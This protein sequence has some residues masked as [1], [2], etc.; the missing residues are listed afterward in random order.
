MARAADVA[1]D[2]ERR[3]PGRAVAFEQRR[4]EIGGALDLRL[5]LPAEAGEISAASAASAASSTVRSLWPRTTGRPATS[6]VSIA[7]PGL[8]EHDLPRGAVERHEGRLVEI[9][10]HQVG[11]HAF[12]QRADLAFHVDRLRPGERRGPGAPAPR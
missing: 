8:G 11:G 1:R 2:A 5:D 9:E 7:A 4:D 6:T 12:L 3:L 10:D